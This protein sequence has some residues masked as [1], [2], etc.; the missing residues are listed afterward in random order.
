MPVRMAC[1]SRCV[2]LGLAKNPSLYLRKYR[3]KGHELCIR[4]RRHVCCPLYLNLNLDLNLNLNPDLNLYLSLNLCLSLFR[5]LFRQLF[6]SPFGSSH[7]SKLEQLWTSSCLTLGRQMPPRRRPVGRPLHGRIVVGCPTNPIGCRSPI[8]LE[9]G[10]GQARRGFPMLCRQ[11]FWV[12]STLRKSRIP[13]PGV[14]GGIIPP[15]TLPAIGR[16]TGRA[17]PPAI[18]RITGR[19]TIPVAGTAI[20]GATL[21][22]IGRATGPAALPVTGRASR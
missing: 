13:C 16:A 5:S 6:A 2:R 3:Q 12:K 15:I 9:A 21:P 1:T 22:A 19:V 17:Y 18:G 4:L 8:R 20:G 7:E 10:I 11:A 14:T